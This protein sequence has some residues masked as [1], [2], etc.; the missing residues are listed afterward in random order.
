MLRNLQ[1][2]MAP[3]PG[4][5]LRSLCLL[6]LAGANAALWGQAEKPSS[7]EPASPPSA[8]LGRKHRRA[9]TIFLNSSWCPPSR[10][11]LTFLWPGHPPLHG[12]RLHRRLRQLPT[13][14]PHWQG[15]PLRG[16]RV[17][18][19]ANPGPAAPGTPAG[20]ERGSARDRERSPV[21]GRAF[22]SRVYCPVP[23]CPCADAARAPGRA[24]AA[25]MHAHIDAHL[26]G[27]LLGDVPAQWLQAHG[28]TRC[29]VVASACRSGM[30]CTPLAV[31]R[32][33]PQLLTALSPWR[34]TTCSC[35]LSTTS[36]Q[37]AHPPSG[38]CR[39]PQ[40]TPGVKS[41][42]GP[43]PRWLTGM[44][45]ERGGSSSCCP[46]ASY[47]HQVAAAN[48]TARP[49]RPTPLIGCNG[50]KKGNGYPFG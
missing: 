41:S 2:P 50:G 23:G 38:M 5:L 36:K 24:T 39:L 13:R 15:W 30:V 44:M 48:G 21:G 25:M 12:L 43:W 4:R 18:E 29:L 26:S 20:G 47:V 27:A 8:T 42:P 31:H 37:R 11:G 16:R 14:R 35:L 17:G 34:S 1:R 33:G 10:A 45:R 9:L 7:S 6:L 3:S 40:D 32:L 46:S 28:R 49:W 22:A 19:A